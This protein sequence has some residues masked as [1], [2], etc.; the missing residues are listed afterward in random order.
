[1]RTV[2]VT[3]WKL[4]TPT[5]AK[6]VIS[7]TG[8]VDANYIREALSKRMDYQATPV[9][10]SFKQIRPGV[11]VGFIR[12]NRAVRA[13]AKSEISAKYRVMSSNILMDNSDKSLWEIKDGASGKYLA[14]HGQ[15]NL[16]ALVEATLQRRTDVPA[17][18]HITIAKA[19]KS[20]L[21]AFVDGEGDMDYGFAVATSDEQVKVLSFNRR[22]PVNVDYDSV[23][24][25]SPVSVPAAL[26]QTV[27]ASLTA[28]ERKQSIDYWRRLYG[29]SPEYLRQVIEQVNQ[30]TTA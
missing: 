23:V 19:S 10:A 21:V 4:K 14:R 8:D 5:L 9:Q 17:L 1:M 11:S 13:V 22:I 27:V 3:D 12:A 25:I 18:R 15:E 6:V 16:E 2:N 20:E 7:Y 26:S 29:Y 28:D 30:G 24:S